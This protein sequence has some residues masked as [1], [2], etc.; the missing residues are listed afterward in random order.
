MD[1]VAI[2][3]IKKLRKFDDINIVKNTKTEKYFLEKR[4]F[5]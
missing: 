2:F 3:F 5:F 4:G 1:F